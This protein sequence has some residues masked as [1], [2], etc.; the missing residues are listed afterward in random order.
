MRAVAIALLLGCA[1]R[2]A[3]PE[4]VATTEA[5][6]LPMTASAAAADCASD[7]ECALTRIPDGGCCPTLC[8]P[9]AVTRERADA[10]QAHVA[11]CSQGKPCPLPPCAP[12][13]LQH[14][15]ACVSGRCVAQSR[16]LN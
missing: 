12:P 5:A 3:P 16:P 10:L 7:S 11:E 4:A 6:S 15:P 9:R 8:T 13:R 14:F 1:S 2:Q